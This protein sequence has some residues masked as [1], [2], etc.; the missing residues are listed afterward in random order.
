MHLAR[1]R[2]YNL[3]PFDDVTLGFER[4]S[5]TRRMTV[6]FGG[7]R[8][9]KTTLLASIATTRPGFALP[10]P[11][12][13][14]QSDGVPWIACDWQLGED[15]PDRPHELRVASPTAQF[16]DE[17]PEQSAFRRKE[18]ALFERRAHEQGGFALVLVSGARWFSRTPNLITQPERTIGRYD[19]RAAPVLDDATR[20]DLTRETKQILAYAAIGSALERANTAQHARAGEAATGIAAV[21]RLDA[22]HGALEEAIAVLLEPFERTWAGVQSDTLEPVFRDRD[23]GL[24]PLEE[25]PRGARH[26]VAIAALGLRALAG[27]YPEV[28]SP[29]E[30]EG[31]ILVDDLELA[32]DAAV[33]RV[34]PQLLL[35]ALPRVQWIVS[36]SSP[37]LMGECEPGD[38]IALR[39]AERRVEI[40]EGDLALLH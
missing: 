20:A 30:R 2:I 31:V 26:L 9:G 6:L 23:G 17:L 35:R 10:P 37:V 28:R 25:I 40:H 22:L 14:R 15:D 12:N 18:Q 27:A 16:E 33:L 36:T 1:A 34:L 24:A 19:V 5:S 3:S 11:P 38:T 13:R 7:D 4:G 21:G 8:T 29:R 32:Q 39:R